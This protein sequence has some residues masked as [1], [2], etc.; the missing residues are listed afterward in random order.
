MRRN[1]AQHMALAPA[2]EQLRTLWIKATGL[3]D[4]AAWCAKPFTPPAG[5]EWYLRLRDAIYRA[6][7]A[8]D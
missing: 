1:V 5:P 2:R 6:R 8:A 7:G 3:A 4:P